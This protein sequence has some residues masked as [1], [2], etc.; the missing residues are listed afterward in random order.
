MKP[1]WAYQFEYLDVVGRRMFELNVG[2]IW[3]KSVN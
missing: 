1:E 3:W 2:E